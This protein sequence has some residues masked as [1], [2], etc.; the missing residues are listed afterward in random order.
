LLTVTPLSRGYDGTPDL[1]LGSERLINESLWQLHMTR[2]RSLRPLVRLDKDEGETTLF[3]LQFQN[4][5]MAWRVPAAVSSG[6]GFGRSRL[7]HLEQE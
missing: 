1:D 5:K 7:P 6:L 4:R 2:I 3:G